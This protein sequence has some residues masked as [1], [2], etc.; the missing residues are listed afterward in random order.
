MRRGGKRELV[1]L[2]IFDGKNSNLC[3]S[4][5]IEKTWTRKDVFMVYGFGLIRPGIRR[6][7]L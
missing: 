5:L 1:C 3:S 2:S 4:L 7:N 6:S